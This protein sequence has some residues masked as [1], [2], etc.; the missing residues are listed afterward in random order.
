MRSVWMI[1]DNA[2]YR[3]ATLRGL[4]AIHPDRTFEAFGSCEDAIAAIE[5]GGAPDVVLMDLGLPGIDGIVG[6]GEIKSRVPDASILVLTVFE[7]DDKIFRALKAGASG[8]LLKSDPIAKLADSVDLVL[9]GSAPI[10]PRIAGRV[11]RMFAELPP[12]RRD[13]GLN[14]RERAVLDCMAQGLVRKQIALKLDLNPH[15]LDYVMRCIYRKLHVNGATAAVALAVRERLV[16]VA[17]ED[18]DP[19]RRPTA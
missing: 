1:E 13:F 18:A 3:A 6:I 4:R 2:N 15:T 12:A 7:D 5:A 14:E 8:Y 19:G 11:L 16:E 9:D 17:D 10:H